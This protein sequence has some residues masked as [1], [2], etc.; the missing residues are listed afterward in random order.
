MKGKMEMS[1]KPKFSPRPWQRKGRLICPKLQ[2]DK[3]NMEIVCRIHE[4][5]F[6]S[7]EDANG[8]LIEKAPDMWENMNSN[9]VFI[10]L[11]NS[12]MRGFCDDCTWGHKCNTCSVDEVIRLLG[13]MKEE[14]EKLKKKVDGEA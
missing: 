2:E 5:R 12:T 3:D 8:R 7:R 1:E 11:I 6:A 13:K 14:T 9:L 10:D 4:N